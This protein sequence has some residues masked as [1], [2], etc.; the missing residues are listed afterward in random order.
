MASPALTQTVAIFRDAYRELNAKRLFWF[1]LAISGLVVAA[2]ATVGLTPEGLQINLGFWNPSFPAPFNSEVLTPATFYKM[3]FVNL[4]IGI[5]LTWAASILA[6]ISVSGIFPDFIAGGS[7][8]LTLSKPISRL[9][10]FFTKYIAALLFVALQVAVFTGGA[11]L[12]IG[13]RGGVWEPS[14]LLAIPIVLVFFSYLFCVCTLFG[15]LTRSTIAS[16]LLTGLIW[17][18][19]WGIGTAENVVLL[20]DTN[21]S[22]LVEKMEEEIDSRRQTIEAIESGEASD[23]AASAILA[24]MSLEA[25]K[26]KLAEREEDLERARS[27]QGTLNR[28]HTGL[29]VAKTVLPKTSETIGLL[30]RFLIADEE[31]ALFREQNQS[32][33]DSAAETIDLGDGQSITIENQE[34]NVDPGDSEVVER[35]EDEI[36]DRP[37][38]WV[39]GTS[40]GFEA[41]ILA[42][43]AFIFCRRDF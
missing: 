13:L 6:L 4:G 33:S 27:S 38:W 1:V 28:W 3:M 36:K 37:V 18:G 2:I 19:Y 30:D 11:F 35:L 43:C 10:L 24:R 21:Q 31:M 42:W 26:A 25:R 12:L 9:R 16:L 41:V 15:L 22:V 32:S 40:L 39:V 7:I 34:A 17:L 8:E 23:G 29:F 14:V 5:W 20:F